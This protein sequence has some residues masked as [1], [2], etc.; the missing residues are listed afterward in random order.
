MTRATMPMVNAGC[1]ARI[2]GKRRYTVQY[3]KRLE[4]R[5]I[6]DTS[7]FSCAPCLFIKHIVDWIIAMELRRLRYFVAVAEEGNVTRAAERLGI[8]QPPLSQQILTLERE[9]DVQV[10]Y[11]RA[12]ACPS[13]KP[14]RR[15][16][17]MRGGC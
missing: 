15:C 2:I 8:G 10:F 1:K 11:A 12:T 6:S 4:S 14:A 16:W 9:L 5:R 13:P 7:P 17:S 3:M